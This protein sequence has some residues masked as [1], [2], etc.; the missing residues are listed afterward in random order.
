M[1]DKILS[2]IQASLAQARYL[3]TTKTVRS[4]TPAPNLTSAE[5]LAQFKESFAKL[6]GTFVETKD[7]VAWLVEFLQTRQ[8][9]RL[10]MWDEKF[11]PLENLKPALLKIGVEIAPLDITQ[12]ER[13]TRLNQLEAV[14]IGLTGTVAACAD[15]G[16]LVLEHGAGR[17]R[18]T[19]L[20]AP[21]HIVFFTRESLVPS[22]ASW[23]P[24]F[25]LNLSNTV[26]ISGPSRTSDIERVLV[27]GAHGPKEVFAVYIE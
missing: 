9:K 22:F 19:S 24:Y 3:P 15:I 17:G 7:G 26:M 12:A 23:L 18:L 16:G 11:L 21:V 27:L 1:R 8:I 5:L 10:T 20:I 2:D 14:E 4:L 13:V 6:N 25:N